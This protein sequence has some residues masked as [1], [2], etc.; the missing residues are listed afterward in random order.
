MN[1]SI[2]E[3]DCGRAI[4]QLDFY[5]DHE[6]TAGER[7]EMD[8]HLQACEP[9][10]RE[11]RNRT[12]LRD[13]LRSAV[14]GVTARGDLRDRISEEIR[15]TPASRPAS[16]WRTWGVGMAAAVALAVAGGTAYELGH[17]RF[18]HASQESYL[19]GIS[20]QVGNIMRVGLGDHVHCAVFRKYPRQAPPPET[21]VSDMGPQFFPLVQL[22]RD[23]IS[24]D[25]RITM[26]HR[27]KYHGRPFVHLAM[28]DGTHLTSLVIA[29]RQPGET[30]QTSGL[31]PALSDPNLP[32]YHS[33]VQRFQI[34]GFQ[35]AGHL[36]YLISDL[37]KDAN[38]RLMA[39]VARPVRDFLKA[40]EL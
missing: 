20:S 40:L 35:T 16:Q 19:R 32:V 11:A 33:N 30:F 26:A 25:Q 14:R 22:I 17:L 28:I 27:C 36:V 9:C 39:S 8:R 18:T 24:P 5:I 34:D 6:L 4:E 7:E 29:E 1:K 12:A 38:D 23:H 15:R 21:I 37:P 3:M 10:M 13:R 2:N 31:T